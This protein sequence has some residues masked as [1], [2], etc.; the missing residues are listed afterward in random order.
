M[1]TNDEKA[2]QT[3]ELVTLFQG[4]NLADREALLRFGRLRAGKTAA[5][6]GGSAAVALPLRSGILQR[7]NVGG[8]H[9]FDTFRSE[10]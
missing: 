4:L 10:V 8:I 6:L 1:Q 7:H 9:L 5:R 3:D 2:S